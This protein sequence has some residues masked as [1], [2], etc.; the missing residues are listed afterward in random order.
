[1]KKHISRIGVGRLLDGC[2]YCVLG[3]CMRLRVFVL[4]YICVLARRGFDGIL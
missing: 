2:I 3:G 4:V 1:M